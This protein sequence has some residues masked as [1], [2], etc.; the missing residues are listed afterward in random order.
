M[1]LLHLLHVWIES[2]WRRFQME[3]LD[4]LAPFEHIHALRMRQLALADKARRLG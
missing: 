1:K 2:A 4:P 3:T